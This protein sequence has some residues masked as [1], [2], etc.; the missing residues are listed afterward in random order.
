M[1]AI[2]KVFIL[3]L[4]PFS[5]FSIASAFDYKNGSLDVN[6]YAKFYT[7]RITGNRE[8]SYLES[9]FQAYHELVINW[10]HR[11]S[12]STLMEG[13]FEG[14][15]TSDKN[16]ND[17]EFALRNIYLK[18]TKEQLGEI[19]LGDFSVNFSQYTL[20]TGLFGLKLNLNSDLMSL[21][22]VS[23]ENRRRTTF[24][25]GDE[26]RRYTHG[27]RLQFNLFKRNFVVGLNFVNTQVDPSSLH[28]NTGVS[29]YSNQVGGIDFDLRLFSDI[30]QIRGEVARSRYDEDRDDPKVE[31]IYDN[32]YSLKIDFIPIQ[33]LSLYLSWER[34][35]PD[36]NSVL[37]SAYSDNDQTQ[38]GFRFSPFEW[39]ELSGYYLR[40]YDDI[41]NNKPYR[42]L[43][44]TESVSLNIYPLYFIE[45]FLQSFNLSVEGSKQY[46]YS[47]DHP[48]TTNTVDKVLSLTISQ[49]ISNFDLSFR[50]ENRW[51]KD[52]I[53]S[54]QDSRSE[55]YT[56]SLSASLNL[57]NIMWAVSLSGTYQRDENNYTN[58]CTESIGWGGSLSAQYD[59]TGTLLM[60]SWHQDESDMG[61]PSANTL[62]TSF[63]AS[64]KQDLGKLI[65]KING[66]IELKYMYTNHNVEEDEYDYKEQTLFM[67]IRLTF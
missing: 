36:F 51:Y 2:V 17:K 10:N 26:Y 64:L 13:Y 62:T 31:A 21:C 14:I 28:T 40:Q 19:T 60:L 67:G 1:R 61:D 18:L 12:N 65:G 42:T 29:N 54:Q 33:I 63:I 25:V 66:D 15:Q 55:T 39:F 6:Y 47:R 50:F 32:A 38:V 5:F 27:G 4:I 23:A 43:S 9:G 24:G 53:D 3:F 37:G 57:L 34:V 20:G 22:L 59:R 44:W 46:T 48:R 8:R 41:D 49:P 35:E 30:L 11:F 16:E 58:G 52:R 45:G 56:G 7:N